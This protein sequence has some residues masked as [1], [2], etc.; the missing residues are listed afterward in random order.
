MKTSLRKRINNIKWPASA[1]KIRLMT[2]CLRPAIPHAS[3]A[4]REGTISRAFG[5]RS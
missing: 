5:G 2:H 1:A 3:L 4:F